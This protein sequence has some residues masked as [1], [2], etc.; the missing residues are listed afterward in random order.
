M[1]TKAIHLSHINVNSWQRFKSCAA[2]KNMA[3]NDLANVM[4]EEFVGDFEEKLFREAYHKKLA[5]PTTDLSKP[6][7]VKLTR[8][9]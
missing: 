3:I 1:N 7:T 9:K 6:I 4:I 5:D 8:T 2:I